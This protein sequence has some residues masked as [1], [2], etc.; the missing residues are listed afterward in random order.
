MYLSELTSQQ[1]AELDRSTVVL[2]PFGSL[3][4]HSYH[5]P[6]ITDSLIGEEI[7]RR[8]DA[9][10]NNQLLR[11]PIQW[12]GYSPHHMMFT[13]SLTTTIDTFITMVVETLDSIATHGFQKVLMLNSH[14]GNIAPLEVALQKIQYKHPDKR[15]VC[16]TYWKV[17]PKEIAEIRETD[18]GGMGH[19]C[20]LET[21]ILLA[22]RPDLVRK[23]KMEKDGIVPQ[24][25]FLF[26]DM[27]DGGKVSV[28]MT[29][30]EFTHHG[31]FGNPLV[32]SA[33]KGEKFL[34]AIVSRLDEVVREMQKGVI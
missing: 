14:G 23:D 11:L 16:A 6:L 34:S 5:L 19:A 12:L 7:A 25:Q 9:Q 29:F 20:E 31:G 3:E 2:A 32:A 27:M 8:L 24:S 1:V 13:G 15:F 10:F 4:Q 17:A 26:K 30:Q 18:M 22:I 33:E 21:S 28:C